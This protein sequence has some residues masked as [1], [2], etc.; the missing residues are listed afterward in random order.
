VTTPTDAIAFGEKLLQL[1]DQGAFTATYKYAVLVGLIDLCLENTSRCGEPA[2]VLTTRQLAEK[3]I[4]L[5]WPHTR[6]YPVLPA[7][8]PVLRQNRGQPGS[9]AEILRAIQTLRGHLEGDDTAPLF[10]VRQALG[11]RF[12]RLVRT[13]EWKLIEMPLPRLQRI[14]RQL[15][16]FVYAIDW[17][18]QISRSR[19]AAYQAGDATAFDGRILLAPGVGEH[20]VRLNGLL[21]PLLYRQWTAEVANINGL[22]ES[23]LEAFLFGTDRM[24]IPSGLRQGLLELQDARCFYCGDRIG[25]RPGHQPEVDHFIPWARYPDNAIEN[26][27]VAHQHCNNDKRDFLPALPHVTHWLGRLGDTQGHELATLSRQ[28]SWAS[29]PHEI[30]GVATAIYLRLPAEM[31]LWAGRGRFEPFDRGA[32]RVVFGVPD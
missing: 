28:E 10:R 9:Q 30:R 11:S 25:A 20:L 1:L 3:V 6:P 2:T 15:A 31:G 26:L 14:G 5:Y 23:R 19:V 29:R 27:V 18:E 7:D 21:R 12:E 17:D 22:P 16:S 13:V 8:Q 32:A 24:A 4:E